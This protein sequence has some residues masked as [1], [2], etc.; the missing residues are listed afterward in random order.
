VRDA[1]SRGDLLCSDKVAK[2]MLIDHHIK[3]YLILGD[4]MHSP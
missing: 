3:I 2:R 1:A 4:F